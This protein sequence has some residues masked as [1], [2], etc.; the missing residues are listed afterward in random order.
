MR[1]RNCSRA[2]PRASSIRY[3]SGIPILE[4]LEV[5]P[6]TELAELLRSIASLLWPTLVFWAL[7]AFRDDIAGAIGRI[8]KAKILGHEFE[9]GDEL[10]ELREA[11]NQ[12][13]N[14]VAD[15]PGDVP[16]H[17]ETLVS[18]SEQPETEDPVQKILET[19][20]RSPKV[21]LLQLA[22]EV[23]T[24]GR[25]VLASTGKW[26][27]KKP[28]PFLWVIERLDS[29]YGLPRYIPSSLKLFL[30]IRNKLVH[31]GVAE[32]RDVV[33]AL[34]SGVTIYRA[35][36]ALPRERNWIHHEGVPVYSDPECLHEIPDVKGVI[37]KTQSS[38]GTTTTYQIFPSTQTYFREGKRVSWEWN[39]GR[40]WSDAWY[41]DPTSNQI[42]LAWNSAGE[43]VGRHYEDL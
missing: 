26:T 28:L 18:E 38:S 33:S 8:K 19:A 5:L 42:R 14:E 32:D 9:L 40:T 36:K 27:E 3:D 17:G 6:V 13:F 23:E 21:A 20:V 34:D 29:H 15:L 10:K 16:D 11:A 35:L 30:N 24:E 43:F 4:A 7:R 25:E 41:R 12:A 2:C 22:M 39:L 1:R 31:G 37:L